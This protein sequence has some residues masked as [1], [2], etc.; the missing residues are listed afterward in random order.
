MAPS[1]ATRL[2][3]AWLGPA[4]HGTA[5]LGPPQ[6]GTA[7]YRSNL[8]PDQWGPQIPQQRE[9]KVRWPPVPLDS[10]PIQVFVFWEKIYS[11][12]KLLLLL[13][14]LSSSPYLSYLLIYYINININPYNNVNIISLSL[15]PCS[16]N[17]CKL[18][19]IFSSSFTSSLSI[20]FSFHN[21]SSTI[22]SFPPLPLSNRFVVH[23]CHCLLNILYVIES[24]YFFVLFLSRFPLCL[25]LL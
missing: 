1:C 19:I 25:P 23:H 2:G 7:R 8:A 17:K 13:L 24:L 12:L 5:R 15:L 6:H 20:L 14:F 21:N 11:G 10:N 9:A 4:Q 3:S 16:F 22:L 18:C